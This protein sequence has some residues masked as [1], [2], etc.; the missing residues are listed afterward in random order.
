MPA[1][2]CREA[3]TMIRH[4]ARFAAGCAAFAGMVMIADAGSAAEVKSPTMDAIKARGELICG[5]DTGIPGFAFQ[6]SAGKWAGLDVA[7]CKAIA[8]AVLGDPEK[9]KY[10]GTTT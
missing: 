9:V 1:S 8:A 10:V 7:Y 6:D 3:Q 5:V 2:Q 4:I